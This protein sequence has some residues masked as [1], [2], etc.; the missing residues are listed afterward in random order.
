MAGSK[1][2]KGSGSFRII[3]G[4]WRGR[5]L[6]I[7]D[8]EGLRPT[9]DRVRETLF[10]WLQFDIRGARCLDLFAGSGSLGLEALSRG[11]ASVTMVEKAPAV[12]RQ[13]KQHLQTLHSAQAEVVQS[14]A[15]QLLQTAT[16]NTYQI[17]FIDPPFRQQ[18][19][20]PSI[21]LLQASGWLAANA[22]IYVESEKGWQGQLPRTW[23]ALREKHAGQV[24]YRLYQVA[25]TSA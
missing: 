13:L 12:A 18:L 17:V 10:N 14:D 25:D 21:D 11:A 3:G 5:R 1:N 19:L 9:T 7:A 23:Q 20:Q 16:A 15:L 22:Y 4:Q 6:A 2:A 8:S 24:T